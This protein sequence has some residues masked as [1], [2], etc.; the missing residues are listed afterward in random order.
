MYL[1]QR[2]VND[3]YYRDISTQNYRAFLDS[4]EEAGLHIPNGIY[5][6][7]QLWIKP[8]STDSKYPTDYEGNS[9]PAGFSCSQQDGKYTVIIF[10]RQELQPFPQMLEKIC[11]ELC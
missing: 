3:L 7:P 2:V 1:S 4:I 11:E 8:K 10:D 6:I 9:L 5:R